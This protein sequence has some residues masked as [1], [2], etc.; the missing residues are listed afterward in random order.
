MCEETRR[1]WNYVMVQSHV[2]NLYLP[3]MVMV[4]LL[5]C[6]QM[7]SHH[8]RWNRMEWN[9]VCCSGVKYGQYLLGSHCTMR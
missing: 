8:S 9:Q 6:A 4:C 7:M 2:I 5:K 3:S 1:F